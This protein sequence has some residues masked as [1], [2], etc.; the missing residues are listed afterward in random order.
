MQIR[1][2]IL[3]WIIG[4]ALIIL[5]VW[6]S[7]LYSLPFT[8]LLCWQ[9]LISGDSVVRYSDGPEAHTGGFKSFVHCIT[10][11]DPQI[12]DHVSGPSYGPEMIKQ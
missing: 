2:R 11:G 6:F 4:I 7:F 1:P 3:L 10:T 9:Q 8:R 12:F 5:T